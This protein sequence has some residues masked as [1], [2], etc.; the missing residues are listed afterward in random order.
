MNKHFFSFPVKD[1]TLMFCVTEDATVVSLYCNRSEVN[2]MLK[3]IDD[4]WRAVPNTE[5]AMYIGGKPLDKWANEMSTMLLTEEETEV[6]NELKSAGF[7][8]I[9]SVSEIDEWGKRMRALIS[10]I[11][12]QVPGMGVA[13]FVFETGV[14]GGQFHW[15]GNIERTVIMPI[16]KQMA[17]DSMTRPVN[18]VKREENP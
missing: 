8:R 18:A 13:L 5:L 10:M 7:K 6:W 3:G 2:W 11:E 16:I 14:E 4:L 17:E 1:R 15:I 9:K 12:A